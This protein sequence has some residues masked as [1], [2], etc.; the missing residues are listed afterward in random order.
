MYAS[1]FNNLNLSKCIPEGNPIYMSWPH[2]LH[3]EDVLLDG[4]D[5]LSP[6]PENHSFILDVDPVSIRITFYWYI[7]TLDF[8]NVS[9]VLSP[10]KEK[11]FLLWKRI[12]L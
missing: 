11:W 2:F 9:S 4:V 5:G 10:I 7:L 6:N 8:P 1:N 3:G 12:C